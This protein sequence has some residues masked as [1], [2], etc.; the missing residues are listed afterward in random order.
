MYGNEMPDLKFE[1]PTI[2]EPK[3][4]LEA[5]SQINQLGR[6][7]HEHAYIVGK[8]LIWTK[9]KIGHGAFL[10]WIEENVWFSEGTAKRFIRFSKICDKENKLLEYDSRNITKSIK[11]IDLKK[12]ETCAIS[13]LQDLI[14]SGKKFSTIYV[15]PPWKYSNQATR[16]STDNHYP[17]LTVEEISEL[18][19]LNLSDEQ[20]HLHLWTTNAFLHDAFH[21]IEKWGFEYKGVF[22]W[23]K[24]QMGIGNYWRVSHEFLLLGV[25]GGLRFLDNSQ[26]SWKKIERKEH[27]EKPDEIRQ[28]IEKVSQPLRLELFARKL[29]KGWI[30]WGNEIETDLF[31]Q[32][33][34]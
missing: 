25:R 2:K 14:A 15:D 7:M 9:K 24:P 6:N 22:V 23:V 27:S 13:D 19:I 8:I 32:Q 12:Q 29:F 30:C 11:L 18:P 5:K 17:T 10:P 21:L 34:K 4:L 33:F 28:I 31:N 20:T 26:M 3:N 1:L 16:A